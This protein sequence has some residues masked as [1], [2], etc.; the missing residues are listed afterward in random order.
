MEERGY[1]KYSKWFDVIEKICD[2]EKRPEELGQSVLGYRSYCD[3]TDNPLQQTY[4]Q[5]ELTNGLYVYITES[6]ITITD[7]LIEDNS[8]LSE[9]RTISI[10]RG[11]QNVPNHVVISPKGKGAQIVYRGDDDMDYCSMPAD[12]SSEV[13][14]GEDT[15]F[16]HIPSDAK[17]LI[18]QG[19]DK[20]INAE[21][22]ESIEEYRNM[23][24]MY[25][26]FQKIV[27]RNISKED[28]A[29]EHGLDDSS[30]G[31]TES[32]KSELDE[33]NIG[34][35]N[36]SEMFSRAED[37]TPDELEQMST[38]DLEGML[39]ATE[40]EN[41][42][43]RKRLEEIRKKELISQIRA[44]VKEG[45]ELDTEIAAVRSNTKENR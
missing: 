35:T 14:I 28:I 10:Y 20:A 25:D 43:K 38:E 44:A 1:G 29:E 15:E 7:E 18:S 41:E 42:A 6:G 2:N 4:T 34:R 19:L 31:L 37:F 23:I 36:D 11:K 45:K 5:Y 39:R 12:C 3:Y 32:E 33:S 17:M 13:S 27:S 21:N 30:Q 22:E 40:D 16:G 26:K 24:E 8:S 9:Y